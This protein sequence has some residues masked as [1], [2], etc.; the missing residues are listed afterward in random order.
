MYE[1]SLIFFF[2]AIIVF[3]V[4]CGRPSCLASQ[5][6]SLMGFSAPLLRC[7]VILLKV[8]TCFKGNAIWGTKILLNENNDC[9]NN[10]KHC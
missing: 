2:F 10:K 6:F 7:I 4:D 5:S 8:R 1:C 3:R 9:N